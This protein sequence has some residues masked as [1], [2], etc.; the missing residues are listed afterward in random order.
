MNQVKLNVEELKDFI[1]H[2]IKNNQHIQS[3][4]KVPVAINVEGN[5]GLGKTS[6]ISQIATELGMQFVKLNL[7]QLEELGDLVGFPVKEFQVKNSEGKSLWIT[8]QEIETSNQKGYKVVAKRMS[9]AAP[10]W[11]QGKGAGGILCLDDYTR[12]D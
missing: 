1:K 5:A 6:A 7:S 9:H 12:A 11:I 8:E 3:E 2:M 4:G 10:D